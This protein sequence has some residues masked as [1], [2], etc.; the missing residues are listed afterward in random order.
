MLEVPRALLTRELL[1]LKHPEPPPKSLR[2]AP[3]ELL[4]ILRLLIRSPPPRQEVG[5]GEGLNMRQRGSDSV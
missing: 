4:G 5:Q 3:P 1:P 2:F